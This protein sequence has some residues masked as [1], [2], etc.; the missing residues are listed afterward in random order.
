MKNEGWFSL[1]IGVDEFIQ[2]DWWSPTPED[3]F[4]VAYNLL[5]LIINGYYV[6]L[7]ALGN[8]AFAAPTFDEEEEQLYLRCFGPLGLR[9]AQF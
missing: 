2:P 7:W 5:F 6:I 8:D 4:P 9:R 3:V 1:T